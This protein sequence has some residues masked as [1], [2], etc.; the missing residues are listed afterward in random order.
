MEE[1]GCER[2]GT[3]D[4]QHLPHTMIVSCRSSYAISS[5][6][7]KPSNCMSMKLQHEYPSI[8]KQLSKLTSTWDVFLSCFM[9]PCECSHLKVE[10]E[11]I[12]N[13]VEKRVKHLVDAEGITPAKEKQKNPR[14][15]PTHAQDQ[16]NFHL[17]LRTCNRAYSSYHS[18][19]NDWLDPQYGLYLNCCSQTEIRTSCTWKRKNTH[20]CT[21]VQQ[22]EAEVIVTKK[23]GNQQNQH[24]VSTFF[25]FFSNDANANC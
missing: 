15:V 12:S 24:M 7:S 4:Y 18:R 25:A 16:T 6:Q 3:A 11:T 1:R 20:T 14:F 22:Q 2:D 10:A 17:D 8:D 9:M 19:I 21:H 23:Q 13:Q 5:F